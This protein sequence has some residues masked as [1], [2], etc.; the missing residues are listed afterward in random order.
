VIKQHNGHVTVYSE[1]GAG[2]TFK[3]YFPL[4]KAM[5]EEE[6]TELLQPERGYETI[7]VAEDDDVTRELSRLVLEKFGYSVIEATDGEH[8][9]EIFTKHHAHIDLVLLDVIMPKLNGKAAY[10][11]MQQIKPKMRALFISGYTAD[12][13]HRKGIFESNI[14]FISKPVTPEVLAR[15][16]REVL[17]A[18]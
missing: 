17:D 7:L 18:D 16:I 13:I 14:N 1:P 12:I 11:A 9:V 10:D 6:S 2:T 8:A 4:V 3:I 15:K 5:A